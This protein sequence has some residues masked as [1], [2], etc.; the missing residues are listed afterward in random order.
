MSFVKE[1]LDDFNRDLSG[2]E[3]EYGEDLESWP[4]DE[5]LAEDAEHE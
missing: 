4:S 2:S 5:E 3:P 1:L